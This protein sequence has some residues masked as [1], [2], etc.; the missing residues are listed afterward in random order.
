MSKV[1]AYL[2]EHILGEVSTNPA[3]LKALSTDASVLEITPEMV[4]Y[5]RVTNDIRKV[6]RFVYQLAEKGHVMAITARGSGTD[7]TG[8]AIGKGISLVMPAH[9]NRIFEFDTKQKLVRLQPGVNAKA[10]NDA[11]LLHGMSIPALPVSAAY[12][13]IGGAVMN[14]ASGPLSGR[15]GDMSQWVHQLEVVLAN[16]DILQTERIS[17]RDLN[18]KKG[19]QTFEGEIYRELDNLIE[20][21]AQL[22]ADR[23]FSPIRDNVGY[24]AIA[25][26]KHKD[27]SFDL[28]PLLVGSQ[29][30]LGI[31]SEMIMKTQFTSSQ[32]TAAFI[33]FGDKEV[34]RDILDKLKDLT[35]SVL[36]YFDG[37]LFEEAEK[38]GK[39]YSFYNVASGTFDA[40][41]LIGFD[42]F[43]ERAR[44][45]KVKKMTKIL[46]G[47]D[48][49][50][51]VEDGQDSDQLFAAREVTAYML[52]PASKELS[53][54][55]LVDGAYVPNER[56]EEFQTAV[57]GL[58]EKHRVLLPIHA[59]VL[60]CTVYTRPVLQLNKV[61]DKQ[62]IFKILDEYTSIVERHG[63][64]LIGEAG[65]GRVKARFAYN[66][67][68]DAVLELFSS[69]KAIF[70][71]HN[72]L[73]PGVK[74][75]TE[76]RQLVSEL[77]SNYDTAAFADHTLYS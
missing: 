3:V 16:G 28:T 24:S 65:E 41:V 19:M 48:A 77:R 67:I 25:N 35:P 8:A 26:V 2:Q 70:D 71:P 42:D 23:L 34:A 22:I 30:T 17:K 9:M 58:G 59:R 45:H 4:V 14:N 6:A 47:I 52:T 39:K 15:Y 61:G 60:D 7:Q 44:Q 38:Q 11:L 1:A 51:T 62:K 37:V 43:S 36:E 40:G 72:I 57:A 68:D 20:D 5:P 73:N 56:F 29:G 18:K 64:H 49:Q 75:S 13:T 76:L 33:T 12:S 69:I 31:M 46:S 74:E 21:N 63:G 66:D 10:V 54:P 27:G 55:P 50:V 32:Q 53:A